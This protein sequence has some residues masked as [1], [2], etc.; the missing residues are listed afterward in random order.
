MA[1]I[2]KEKKEKLAQLEKEKQ[3]KLEQAFEKVFNLEKNYKSTFC[4][5]SNKD[6]YINHVSLKPNKK[7]NKNDKYEEDKCAINKKPETITS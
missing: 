2:Q 4:E 3:Q 7:E 5:K 6:K 1:L